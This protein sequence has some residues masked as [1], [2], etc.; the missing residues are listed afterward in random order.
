[1]RTRQLPGQKNH[2][3]HLPLPQ[4]RLLVV[5]DERVERML[6]TRAVAPMGYTVDAVA[7]LTDATEHLAAHHYDAVVLDLSLGETE[8]ISLLRAV[9]DSGNEP[10]LI[11]LSHLDERVLTA[12]LR[13]AV[14]MGLRVAGMLQKPA[15]PHALRA[16]LRDAPPGQTQK[17]GRD[18][19]PPSIAELAKAIQ[20]GVIV[21]H[22]QPQVSLR[23]G[24]VV[25]VEALARWPLETG[26]GPTPEVFVPLAEQTGLIIPLTFHI[27]RG[28]LEACAR[29]RVRHPDCRV[30][31]NISPLVLADPRLPD[32]IERLLAET[33]LGPGSLI[34]EITE[35]TV[36]ANPLMAA[37]VLTRLR[38]KGIELSID[39]FGT[40]HS[41]LLTLLRLP[42]SEL[43]I[44]RSFI[45]LCETD[46]E[47][48]KIV[49]A[50]ISMA[51]ELGLRVVAEGIETEPI[52]KRLQQVSCE[53]GQGWYFAR[54][55]TEA[56][57]IPWLAA[58]SMVPA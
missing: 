23:D 46:A 21:P 45:S 43:K 11:F 29:W 19:P 42:F 10:V 37:E 52:V 54:A 27:M 26:D 8:G 28:S 44:D 1:M 22:F 5:D 40:G 55:M 39:D 24:L 36:I 56:A 6:V 48:W 34:A 13:L 50:T 57:L 32:E 33:G 18:K 47:A 49:R 15:S 12:S 3:D 41:S 53:V 51:R 31:V 38:I 16:L 58:F 30:A 9:R 7:N 2:V 14:G 17:P 25:G 35:S 20:N 4:K